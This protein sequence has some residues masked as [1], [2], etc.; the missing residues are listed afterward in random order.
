MKR[1]YIAK[2]AIAALSVALL[3]GCGASDE[4][5]KLQSDVDGLR[6]M[7]TQLKDDSRFAL[8]AAHKSLEVAKE[9]ARKAD[10]AMDAANAAQKSADECSESCGRLMRRAQ[11]K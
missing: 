3:S 8:E 6:S 1:T 9:N 7:V 10:A 11:M 4:V 5:K 2:F